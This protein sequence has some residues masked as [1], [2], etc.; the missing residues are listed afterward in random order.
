MNSAS[1]SKMLFGRSANYVLCCMPF[2]SQGKKLISMYR[3]CL[4][5]DVQEIIRRMVW[6][7]VVCCDGCVQGG[8]Q[9][10]LLLS[11]ELLPESLVTP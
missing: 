6:F 10:G 9:K 5:S 4:F 3:L 2:P 11:V 8:K 1:A 7:G